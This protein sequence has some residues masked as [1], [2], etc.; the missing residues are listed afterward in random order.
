MYQ[1]SAHNGTVSIFDPPQSI[2]DPQ[3]WF[4]YIMLASA[5]AGVAYF[6]YSTYFSHG[7]F[8]SSWFQAVFPKKQKP[9]TAKEHKKRE[10]VPV[11]TSNLEE[12]IP[13]HHLKKEKETP[14]KRK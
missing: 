13:S 10:T 2:F 5:L 3:A 8:N 11:E 7:L 4:L 14:R 12:W 6:V 1:T 9:R